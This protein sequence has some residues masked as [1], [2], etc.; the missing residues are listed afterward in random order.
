MTEQQIREA[1]IAEARTWLRTPW[2]HKA[3]VK[4]AGVD[5]AQFLRA[6]YTKPPIAL[7]PEFDPGDYPP[8]W[9]MHRSEERF[10]EWVMKYAVQV[11]RP[12]MGDVVMYK[13][14]HCFAHGGIVVEW[15]T[16]IHSFRREGMVVISDGSQGFMK[17]RDV[18][19][20][21]VLEKK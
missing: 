6:V 5:C 3:M 21:S 16:I 20:W 15:P 14:G 7:V 4:G 18:S 10:L 17:D 13:V 19:F 11:E 8:D 9:M 1:I 12:K 2:H